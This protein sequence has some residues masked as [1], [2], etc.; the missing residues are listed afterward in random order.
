[1]C[2]GEA[3]VGLKRAFVAVLAAAWLSLLVGVAGAGEPKHAALW[4]Q[5]KVHFDQRHWADGLPLLTQ[6][7]EA[8]LDEFGDADPVTYDYAF[9]LAEVHQLLNDMDRAVPQME[10]ALSILR[11][12]PHDGP[13]L[14]GH[15]WRL[16]QY[17]HGAGDPAA[18]VARL[19]EALA[20]LADSGHDELLPP[21]LLELADAQ[22]DLGDIPAVL[23]LVQRL[24]AL[25]DVEGKRAG[26]VEPLNRMGIALEWLGR[27]AESEAAYRRALVIAE[28]ELGK[29]H[30]VVANVLNSLGSAV[31]LRGRHA[32]EEAL[33]L[34]GLAI[35]D[36][37]GEEGNFV[38]LVL[39]HNLATLREN[40]GDVPGAIELERRALAVAEQTVGKRHPDYADRLDSLALR[41]VDDRPDAA[42]PMFEQVLAIRLDVLGA[43]HPMV[44]IAYERLALTELQAGRYDR[45][46]AHDDQALKIYAARVGVEHHRAARV[47]ERQGIAM[48][49]SGKGAEAAEELLSRA[50]DKRVRAFGAEHLDVAHSDRLLAYTALARDEPELALRRMRDALN[51]ED[52]L[53]RQIMGAGTDAHRRT[54]AAR[55]EEATGHVLN[56]ALDHL[57]DR[58]DALELAAETVLRRKALA[59]ELMTD[60]LTRWRGRA[61]L[62]A[63][64]AARERLARALLDGAGDQEAVAGA[65]QAVSAARKQLGQTTASLAP[66]PTLAEVAARLAEDEVLIEILSYQPESRRGLPEGGRVYGAIVIRRSGAVGGV[67]LGEV[68][69]IDQLAMAMRADASDPARD[70]V[71]SARA[72]FDAVVAPLLPLVG[73]ARRWLISPDGRLFLVPFAALRDGDGQLL[74]ERLHVSY[75]NTGRE[76]VATRA[77]ASGTPPL[78]VGA[79]SFAERTQVAGV[80]MTFPP[81]PGTRAEVE[82]VSARLADRLGKATVSMGAAATEAMVKDA[83]GPAILHL[84]THGYFL[85]ED[86]PMVRA[87]DRGVQLTRT[88][89]VSQGLDAQLRSALVFAAPRGDQDGVLTA[90]EAATM[91]LAGTRLVVMSGCETGVG[92]VEDAQGVLGLRRAFAIAGA[93]TQVMSLWRV[94]DASTRDLM[95][96]YYDGLLAGRGRADALRDAQLAQSHAHPVHWAG[97]VVSGATGPL[98][99]AP[100]PPR[101]QPTGGC[102]CELGR[103]AHPGGGGLLLLLGLVAWRRRVWGR[104]QP[105]HIASSLP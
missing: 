50:R 21:Y 5:A 38:R 2:G 70:P 100:S 75:L 85:S 37:H 20:L 15:L 82:A 63:L 13:Q 97:F 74:L 16:S 41:L 56:L 8:A 11:K 91:N 40:L 61:D 23:P 36:A 48:L 60:Q 98:W 19:K 76:L 27:Y 83:Q 58:S 81:L 86:A 87:G 9:K 35:A 64:I 95:I 45:A 26:M 62:H 52:A 46:R 69:A 101:V 105:G 33:Y 90:Y 18:R 99:K 67:V 1:V 80:T 7:F 68:G 47:L 51:N 14:A 25:H 66:P 103:A 17:H 84:A 73:D 79:P 30:L 44:A 89:S 3:T 55:L 54:L 77:E 104:G 34:R 78:L 72:L 42:R 102:A 53:M 29:D 24:I 71:A 93:E 31:S 88:S 92:A 12:M 10:R 96:R 6:S 28:K 59:L 94:G 57:P 32:E 39:F 43:N 22:D 65:L 49:R 4:K